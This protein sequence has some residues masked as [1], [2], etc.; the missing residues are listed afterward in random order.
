MDSN[1]KLS[2]KETLLSSCFKIPVKF[3]SEKGIND[4]DVLLM[5]MIKTDN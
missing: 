4:A 2:L 1:N 5:S 3:D